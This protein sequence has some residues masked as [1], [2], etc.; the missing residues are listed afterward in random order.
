M[1]KRQ[2]KKALEDA[3]MDMAAV[4]ELG[5]DE[6]EIFIDAGNGRGDREAVEAAVAV[7][8]KALG[9]T[10][11]YWTGCGAFVLQEA[12]LDMGDW[13]DRSSRWHY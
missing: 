4:V 11:G 6:V 12:P 8:S 5:R 13:C 1:N 9:W 3:G 10:G 2:V 7:A